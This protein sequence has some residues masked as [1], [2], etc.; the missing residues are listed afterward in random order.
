MGRCNSTPA[1]AQIKLTIWLSFG[2]ARSVPF[3]AKP[4]S[5]VQTL[6]KSSPILS[7]NSTDP[8]RVIAFNTV[9]HWS[10]DVSECFEIQ[11]RCDIGSLRVPDHILGVDGK[12]IATPGNWSLRLM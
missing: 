7:G 4:K 5:N 9:E 10:E 11:A 3:I 8:I 6:K 12:Y 2:L 1:P